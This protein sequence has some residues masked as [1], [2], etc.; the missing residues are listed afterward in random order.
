MTITILKNS[1]QPLFNNAQISIDTVFKSIS[2]EKKKYIIYPRFVN[3]YILYKNNDPKL[4]PY[5]M[6]KSQ[7]KTFNFTTP[8]ACK[9]RECITSIKAL[10]DK[11]GDIHRLIMEYDEVATN[12]LYP[13]KIEN[14]LNISLEMKL[15]IVDDKPIKEKKVGKL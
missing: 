4:V 11:D 9:K 15:G 12:K 1:F 6:G 7:E 5:F 2:G 13:N 8:K 3:A 10:T 14:S